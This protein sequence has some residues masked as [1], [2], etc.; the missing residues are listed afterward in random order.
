VLGATTE[1][2]V[3]ASVAVEAAL[4]HPLLTQ[5][6]S[7]ERCHR[8]YPVTFRLEGNRLMEGV[9]DLAFFDQGAWTV[10]DFKTDADL[11]GRRAQYER[12]LQ[13]YAHAL[14]ELTQTPTRAV[15]LGV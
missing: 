7:A 10:V 9:I 8:E 3:A 6:R 12:Q 2:A 15:L 11:S 1:E 13:W 4:A 5:A 14:R